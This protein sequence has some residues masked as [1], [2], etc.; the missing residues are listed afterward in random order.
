MYN[1][2]HGIII[3]IIMRREDF[4]FWFLYDYVKYPLMR[5]FNPNTSKYHNIP[6]GIILVPPGVNVFP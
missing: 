3:L 1:V 2:R 6:R 5:R 4:V